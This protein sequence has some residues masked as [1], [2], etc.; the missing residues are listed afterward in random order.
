MNDKTKDIWLSLERKGFLLGFGIKTVIEVIERE[1]VKQCVPELC[2][3]Q[4]EAD[5]KYSFWQNS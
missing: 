1:V 4:E 3:N 2:S 5:K